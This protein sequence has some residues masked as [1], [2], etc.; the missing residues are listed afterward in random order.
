[1]GIRKLNARRVKMNKTILLGRITD[2]AEIKQS[3]DTLYTNF[4]LAHTSKG[5]GGKE[6]TLFL[7]C[8]A[9]NYIAKNLTLYTK[10]G[11]RILAEGELLQDTWQDKQSGQKRTKLKLQVSNFYFMDSK[12]DNASQQASKPAPTIPQAKPAQRI[13]QVDLTASDDIPF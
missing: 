6:N 7:D 12:Q 10:K 11:S 13:A 8:V 5:K 2:N 1:M 4:T 3:G 9:F